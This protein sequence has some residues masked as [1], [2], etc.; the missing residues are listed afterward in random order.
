MDEVS[1]PWLLCRSLSARAI[2]TRV[3]LGHLVPLIPYPTPPPPPRQRKRGL[4][5]VA[6]GHERHAWGRCPPPTTGGGGVGKGGGVLCRPRRPH[7]VGGSPPP[8]F[9]RCT[10]APPPRGRAGPTV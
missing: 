4:L 6:T 10:R 1:S 9:S 3:R 2:R 7:G 8:L 5:F